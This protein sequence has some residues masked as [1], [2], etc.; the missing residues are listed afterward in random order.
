M[1]TKG[2]LEHLKKRVTNCSE[3]QHFG[4]NHFNLNEENNERK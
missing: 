2:I 1:R 4:Q 3:P